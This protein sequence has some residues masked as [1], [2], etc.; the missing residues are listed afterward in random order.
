MNQRHRFFVS[1][2]ILVGAA[3]IARPCGEHESL[4]IKPFVHSG[5]F[6]NHA[7]ESL[8][9]TLTALKIFWATKTNWQNYYRYPG[10]IDAWSA[11][12]KPQERSVEPIVTWIGHAS[13]LVQCNNC[14]ILT[15]PVFGSLSLL[16][17]R[18]TAPGI[19]LADLP[20]IHAVVIS[21][22]H[23]DHM[24]EASLLAL[25]AGNAP[26]FLV[27]RGT[28]A[29]FV[30]RG[31]ASARVHELDWHDKI[32]LRKHDGS[33]S[34][35]FLPAVHWCHRVDWGWRGVAFC[36][37]NT[38]L[39]GSWLFETGNLKL[40]FAGDSAVGKHF[41]QIGAHYGPIDVAL[42]PIGPNEPRDL[43]K[44]SHLSA[45]EAV[46]AF[47][48]L[49]AR[50]FI[51]MHWGTFRLGTDAFDDPIIRL[52]TY[53]QNKDMTTKELCLLKIGQPFNHARACSG[54]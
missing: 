5:T 39:W 52:T 23:M 53:W 54:S 43:M 48:A 38:S 24:D 12:E 8:N 21:H 45:E 50:I 2:F 37:M 25:E 26:H 19:A 11:R 20:P 35:T 46:D 49:G 9:H 29:W 30:S 40:Y 47:L 16:Y 6:Y 14:N 44:D 32:M 3:H 41:A 51:P 7:G 17:P 15:D 27:P 22:N 33:V 36:G 10:Q 1:V 34:C 4:L 42:M 13:F 31:C 18:S 28:A